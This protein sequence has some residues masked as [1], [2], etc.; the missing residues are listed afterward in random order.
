MSFVDR[1]RSFW[2]PWVAVG[3]T[4]LI[5]AMLVYLALSKWASTMTDFH[6]V[7][8]GDWPRSASTEESLSLTAAIRPPTARK[9][10]RILWDGAPA[11]VHWIDPEAGLFRVAPQTHTIGFHTLSFESNYMGGRTRSAAF[12]VTIGP[13]GQSDAWL[14][15][16]VF[17]FIP[18]DLID[19]REPGQRDMAAT[20]EKS[21][22]Q[23]ISDRLPA[24]YADYIR[25]LD[26]RPPRI[27]LAED[28]LR[29]FNRIV[30]NADSRVDLSASIRFELDDDRKLL[31]VAH[32]LN[33]KVEVSGT[34]SDDI[35]DL[36]S[37]EGRKKG[38]EY[39]AF[40]GRVGEA[41][42]GFIGSIAG[43]VVAEQSIEQR[44]GDKITDLV[45]RD[46]LPKLSD[47]LSL[48]APLTA[49]DIG[50]EL[51][52]RYAQP[53][54]IQADVG[55]SAIFDVRAR[56][57][58]NFESKN[59]PFGVLLTGRPVARPWF[60]N[61]AGITLSVDFV[62]TLL[63]RLWESGLLDEQ[64]AAAG[65]ID[66]VNAQLQSLGMHID[67]LGFER[68]PVMGFQDGAISGVMQAR[69][70]HAGASETKDA[71]VTFVADAGFSARDSQLELELDFRH[72]YIYCRVA[73]TVT[74]CYPELIDLARQ[75]GP[76]KSGFSV[77]LAQRLSK[78]ARR[79]L[80]R[81]PNGKE[82]IRV[83]PRASIFVSGNLA[84]ELAPVWS[85]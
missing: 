21:I 58:P 14:K 79:P 22:E 48:S 51:E 55:I 52:L 59:E 20:L 17:A 33:A 30:F 72:V 23:A 45:R 7:A 85:D 76:L 68:P 40:A 50:I 82:A 53:P 81:Y 29:F 70:R 61:R 15:D 64:M 4:G 44:F 5:L 18:K 38:R 62:N 42:G 31:V 13:L 47:A 41:I 3:L 11:A 6:V 32:G 26:V 83:A 78:I 2:F 8:R 19:A 27:E 75:S 1:R 77:D 39:G 67:S 34:T 69:V 37:D 84:V 24:E 54:K 35:R 16:A 28:E 80:Y 25:S 49:K 12:P 36:A 56:K 74:P 73:Q 63:A 60:R 46:V 57:T 43:R 71:E 10:A 66:T 65:G 9:R